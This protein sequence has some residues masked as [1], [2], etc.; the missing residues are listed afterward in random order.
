MGEFRLLA[1]AGVA[2]SAIGALAGIAI[3]LAAGSLMAMW[4]PWL[5]A[6]ALAGALVAVW[7]FQRPVRWVY[8][9]TA[10]MFLEA[11]E[12][13]VFAG[14]ARIRAVQLILLPALATLCLNVL[15]GQIRIPRIPLL[16]PLV[17][18]LACN[19]ASALFGVSLAQNMKIF[20]L[21]TS[22][23]LVYVTVYVLVRNDPDAWP[24]VFRFFVLIGVLE[25]AYGLYQVAAGIAN[26]RFGTSLPIGAGGMVHVGFLGLFFG[27]PYGTL[28]EPDVYGAVCAYYALLLGLMWLSSSGRPFSNRFVFL[29]GAAALLGL[30]VGFVRASWLAFIAGLSYAVWLRLTSRLRPLRAIRLSAAAALTAFVCLGALA[31]SPDIRDVVARRFSARSETALGLQNARFQQMRASFRLFLQSPIVGNGPGSFSVLGVYGAHEEYWSGVRLEQRVLYD[32]SLA[33]TLLND[34][35]LIGV[36]AFLILAAAYFRHVRRARSRLPDPTARN[37]AM[38][39]HCALVGLFVSFLF[40]Q[41]FWMPFT[42]VFIAMSVLLAEL[43]LVDA[44][45]LRDTT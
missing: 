10:A 33:T 40:T 27:R 6:A 1:G 35:G 14:G 15:G 42:W 4:L 28:P 29:A 36:G 32:P 24:T 13:S 5:P 25:V 9:L 17:F 7:C 2:L 30:L 38:A 26:A 39:V 12:L 37:A 20:L 34:T 44:S 11:N 41:Y 19:L 22:L 18:Y 3:L 23:I 21:L 16:V 31:F 45:R 43:P 8:L